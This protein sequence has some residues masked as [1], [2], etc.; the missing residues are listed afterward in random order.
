M[1]DHWLLGIEANH[2]AEREAAAAARLAL[3]AAAREERLAM[4]AAA[5]VAE[6][7]PVIAFPFKLILW[8]GPV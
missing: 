8:L 7:F 1:Y 4:E 3:V 5:A 2:D 6:V